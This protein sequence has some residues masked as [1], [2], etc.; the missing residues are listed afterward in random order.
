[1]LFIISFSQIAFLFN[2]P[3]FSIGNSISNT[4]YTTTKSQCKLR[5]VGN[6]S[7]SLKDIE[8]TKSNSKWLY[9]TRIQKIQQRETIK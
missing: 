8:L 9:N 3:I 7:N 4:S 1:M 2:L 6:L 5:V